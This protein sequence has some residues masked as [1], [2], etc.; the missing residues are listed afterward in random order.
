M[1]SDLQPVLDELAAMRG[2]IEILSPLPPATRSRVLA[3]LNTVV[4]A[5]LPRDGEPAGPLR[6]RMDRLERGEVPTEP[7]SEAVGE[8]A[9]EKRGMW[10][11]KH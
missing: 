10:R 11:G 4:A 2:L 1:S 9:S 5:D 7:A 8:E 6:L 3:W